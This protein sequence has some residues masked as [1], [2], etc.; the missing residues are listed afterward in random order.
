MRNNYQKI[1]FL[2]SIRV[3]FIVTESSMKPTNVIFC[4]GT[5]TDLPGCIVKPGLLKRLNV[6]L[7]LFKQIIAVSPMT[8]ELCKYFHLIIES[9]KGFP[10]DLKCLR[11]GDMTFENCHTAGS[12]PLRNTVYLK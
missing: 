11:G 4:L 12:K 3:M 10:L 8:R 2:S 1:P 9:S 5:K 6:S 7:T